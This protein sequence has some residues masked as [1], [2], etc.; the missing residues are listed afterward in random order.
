MELPIF[1]T[2]PKETPVK[3]EP[4]AIKEVLTS[5][6]AKLMALG[7][8]RETHFISYDSLYYRFL[9]AIKI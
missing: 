2:Q 7:A 8:F 9:R 3:P 6:G 4:P 1:V 5:A